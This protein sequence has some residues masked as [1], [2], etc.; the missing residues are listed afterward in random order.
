MQILM[1][2][3]LYTIEIPPGDGWY[4]TRRNQFQVSDKN[5]GNTFFPKR[6]YDIV[7]AF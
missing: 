1:I 3:P 2:V 4:I 5:L 7:I 6:V